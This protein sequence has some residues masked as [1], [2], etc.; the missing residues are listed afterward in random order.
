MFPMF[1]I[2]KCTLPDPKEGLVSNCTG[3]HYWRRI[4]I[5]RD[6]APGLQEAGRGEE[7][8]EEVVEGVG[9]ED[10]GDECVQHGNENEDEL[11]PEEPIQEETKTRSK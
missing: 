9:G 1:S 4:T 3:F 7:G 11:C 10:N 6:D 5:I 2:S 8:E